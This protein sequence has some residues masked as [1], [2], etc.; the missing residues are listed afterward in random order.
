MADNDESSGI[1]PVDPD[2]SN[3]KTNSLNSKIQAYYKSVREEYELVERAANAEDPRELHKTIRAM[4][5]KQAADAARQIG[6]LAQNAKGEG[7][8]LSAA[9][10]ILGATMHAEGAAALI[11]PIQQLVD[12]LT[13]TPTTAR[14]EVDD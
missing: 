3:E 4:L 11:D 2:E 13:K 8:R 6:W 12:D 10:F 9:K 7:V 1:E 14:E 5:A